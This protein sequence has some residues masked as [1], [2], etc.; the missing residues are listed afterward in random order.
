MAAGRKGGRFPKASALNG[1]HSLSQAIEPLSAERAGA[2]ID[3][4]LSKIDN[5]GCHKSTL[6]PEFAPA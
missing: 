1:G 4:G 3:E 6:V 2:G 5:G